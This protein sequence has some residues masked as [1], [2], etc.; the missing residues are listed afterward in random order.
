MNC[1]SM[2]KNVELNPWLN[3][4]RFCVNLLSDG[5]NWKIIIVYII[6]IFKHEKKQYEE[7][8]SIRRCRRLLLTS[9]IQF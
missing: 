8:V 4:I 1:H 9:L 5:K 3:D 6:T 7:V 2:M